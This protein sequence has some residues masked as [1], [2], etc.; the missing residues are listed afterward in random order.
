MPPQ[1]PSSTES[2]APST[3]AEHSGHVP[4]PPPDRPQTEQPRWW[5]PEGDDPESKQPESDP[6]GHGQYQQ[7]AS[8]EDYDNAQTTVIR[9]PPYQAYGQPQGQPPSGYGYPA[10]YAGGATPSAAWPITTAESRV[11]ARDSLALVSRI[12]LAVGALLGLGY[13]AWA[14]TARRG[15]FADFADGVSVTADD[16]RTSDRIDTVFLIVAGLVAAAAL[17]VWVIRVVGARTSGALD[18]AGLAVAGVGVIVVVVGLF[19]SSGVSDGGSTVEQGENGVTATLVTGSGFAL[20]AIGLLL[21]LL[22]ARGSSTDSAR[23]W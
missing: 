13:A 5:G 20:V 4:P 14:F 22:A 10:T 21:G 7:P 15:I 16:A 1:P 11:G 3:P 17:V 8:D 19:L 23:G 6:L 2:A 18:L 9:Q 12:L